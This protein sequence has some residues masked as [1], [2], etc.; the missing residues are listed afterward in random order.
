MQ[1]QVQIIQPWEHPNDDEEEKNVGDIADQGAIQEQ[2]DQDHIEDVQQ[3][4]VQD[5]VSQSQYSVDSF[6]ADDFEEANTNKV[7][8]S[9]KVTE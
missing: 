7:H 1:H 5:D 6:D 9:I 2:N 4:A 3:D 8:D